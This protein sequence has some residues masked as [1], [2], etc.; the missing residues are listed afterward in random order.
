MT[1]NPGDKLNAKLIFFDIDG[2]LLNH[3][4]RLPASTRK[5]VQEL[6][7]AGH[8]VAIATGRGPFMFKE[9]R[10]ELGID[11]FISFNG[12]YVEWEGEAIYINPIPP[13][14]I[15]SVTDMAMLNNHPMVFMDRD[16]MKSSVEY[17]AYVK[18]SIDSL[19][20]AHPGHDPEYFKGRPIYQCLLFCTIGEEMEYKDR[21]GSGLDFVRWHQF[22]TDI[23]PV[24]GSK[25]RG[26]RKV[27]DKLGVDMNDVYAFGDGLNDIEMLEMVENSVAMGNALDIV[28]E[29]ARY[30]TK[31]VEDDGIRHGL[32]MLKLL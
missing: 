16:T 12:Q 21:F 22:S 11:L 17:H 15:Q 8:K 14:L 27:M 6:K 13:E 1:K 5:A 2:T 25:A 32:R 23:L 10:E 18:E 20:I 31:D 26:I 3:E 24:G 19:K 7:L 9:L 4:K 30:V 29:K 28:K